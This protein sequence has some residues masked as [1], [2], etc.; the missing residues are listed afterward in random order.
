VILKKGLASAA[1]DGWILCDNGQVIDPTGART[2]QQI[3]LTGVGAFVPG[4]N[5]L[6]MLD[7]GASLPVLA[8][9][10]DT[11]MNALGRL[12]ASG[13]YPSQPVRLLVWGSDGVAFA[14][15]NQLFIGRSEL[16]AA[17]PSFTA[18]GIV[19]S[20]TLTTG[21]ISPGEILSV[22]GSN[23]GTPQGRTLEFSEPRQV[24]TMLAETQVWFDG[25]PGTMLYAGGG[26]INVVAP[27]GLAGE[28][29]T[30]IQVWYQGIPSA[31][32]P[33]QVSAFAPGIFTQDGSGK[34]ASATLNSDGT[35]NTANHPAPAGSIISLYG[36]GAG[37][38]QPSLAD[39]QEDIY[40]WQLAANVQVLL[41]GSAV[42]VVYAGAAPSL[43]A[44][45]IQVNFQIP[46]NFPPSPSATV[47]LNVG[48]ILSP[49][50][51]TVSTH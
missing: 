11:A 28:T 29:S 20:A 10:E 21:S 22:F 16:A 51:V 38:T 37:E 26:Q 6:L 12:Q 23:L 5:R 9:Y 50:G 45:V 3:D 34:N 15:N 13:S 27:F 30:R 31:I 42:P 43:V 18:A 46:A 8:A 32:V 35:L 14:A 44:G 49:T 19:N 17:A 47:Q 7:E 41:D 4:Q 1:G 24:S 33:L 36:T 2:T 25:L 40:A 39:G 48:G